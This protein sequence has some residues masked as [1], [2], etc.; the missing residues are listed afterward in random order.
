LK[1]N[2]SD[3]DSIIYEYDTLTSTQTEAKRLA[4]SGIQNAIVVTGEQ[5][6]GKGRC[7]RN[8]ESPHGGGLYVSF[9]I[10][11]KIHP[12]KI[13]F[14]NFVAGLA[15][16]S[17][18]RDLY[19]INAVLK[20]PNDV[21]IESEHES[22][23]TYKKICGILSEAAIN[24]EDVKFCIV[25]IGINCKKDAIPSELS[26]RACALDEYI[27]NIDNWNLLRGISHEFFAGV[28]NFELYGSDKL[29]S[30]Y[31]SFC[32]TIGKAVQI[33]IDNEIINGIAKGI[34][35]SGELLVETK[36]GIEK[37]NAADVFHATILK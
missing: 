18:L 6:D 19:S 21:I 2:N 9:L 12:S 37:F 16:M 14:I 25:G 33:V 7:G 1:T 29:L 31:S 3:F 8:W 4:L 13:H 35:E 10:T 36:N 22:F 24:A 28:R 30:D 27:N 23:T 11:P 15:V 32:S 17:Y 34:G 20:W 5:T 26:N